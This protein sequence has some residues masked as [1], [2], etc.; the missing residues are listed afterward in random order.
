MPLFKM[1]N[2]RVKF[3]NFL[4]YFSVHYTDLFINKTINNNYMTFLMALHHTHDG[5]WYFLNATRA[6]FIPGTLSTLNLSI[7]SHPLSGSCVFPDVISVSNYHSYKEKTIKV[8]PYHSF[9]GGP[10]APKKNWALFSGT[11]PQ[12]NAKPLGCPFRSIPLK[13]FQLHL[14]WSLQHSIV[15]M[16]DYFFFFPQYKLVTCL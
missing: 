9:Y 12:K 7:K 5:F 13:N 10:H 15:K 6:T 3:R 16:C 8:L 11:A 1:K 2:W 14:S 4:G